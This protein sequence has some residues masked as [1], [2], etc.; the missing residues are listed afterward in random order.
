MRTFTVCNSAQRARSFHSNFHKENGILLVYFENSFSSTTTDQSSAT[1]C[2]PTRGRRV[3]PN[4]SKLQRASA[5][6]RVQ[7]HAGRF[8]LS[9]RRS[10]CALWR[11]ES[12]WTGWLSPRR[13]VLFSLQI[14]YQGLSPRCQ[15]PAGLAHG[16]CVSPSYTAD[17]RGHP[18]PR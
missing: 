11:G 4:V 14:T 16:G 12:G 7:I 1:S 15:G 6:S 9:W 18:H 5:A 3:P 10:F 2:I 17:P 8:W 13:V